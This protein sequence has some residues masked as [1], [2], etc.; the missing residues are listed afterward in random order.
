MILLGLRSTISKC[1]LLSSSHRLIDSGLLELSRRLILINHGTDKEPLLLPS[2]LIP[3]LPP[4]V[5]PYIMSQIPTKHRKGLIQ[6]SP[7][8]MYPFNPP[9][10][11]LSYDFS[12]LPLLKDQRS[13]LSIFS[14]GALLVPWTPEAVQVSPRAIQHQI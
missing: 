8:L 10:K 1:K 2:G 3:L 12:P 7:A 4:Q 5:S 14:T 13:P 11:A 9:H 6:G